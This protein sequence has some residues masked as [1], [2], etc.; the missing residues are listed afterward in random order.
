MKPRFTRQF[1]NRKTVIKM[2]IVEWGQ[3]VRPSVKDLISAVN[4]LESYTDIEHE[5][6]GTFL[7]RE[8]ANGLGG[9]SGIAEIS[10]VLGNTVVWNQAVNYAIN[11]NATKNGV[12]MQVF[13][14][15]QKVIISGEWEGPYTGDANYYGMVPD[16][17]SSYQLIA[18]HKYAVIT[19]FNLFSAYIYFQG[20]NFGVHQGS[21]IATASTTVTPVYATFRPNNASMSAQTVN[22]QG[23]FMMFDLTA[24]YGAGNEPQT[25]AEFEAQYGSDFKPY[26]TPT[27]L[28]SNIAGIEGAS[29]CEFP[30]QTLRSAG[31]AHDVMTKSK[32]ERNIGIITVDGDE[33]KMI[34]AQQQSN[35]K[36]LAYRNVSDRKNPVSGAN[37]NIVS[38]YTNWAT[39]LAICAENVGSILVGA[40]GNLCIGVG[41]QDDANAAKTAANAMLQSNPLILY[42]EL[43][44]PT[45]ETFAE[46]LDLTYRVESDGTEAWIVPEGTSPTSSA[47]TATISYKMQYEYELITE[48]SFDNFCTALGTALNLDIEKEW[49]DVTKEWEFTIASARSNLNAIDISEREEL[50]SIDDERDILESNILEPIEEVDENEQR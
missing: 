10:R 14:P 40:T 42:Y 1:K 44:T 39:N 13:A 2:S 50:Y 25:V 29:S 47:P 33:T 11:H 22:E 27:L 12:Q 48:K 3:A 15:D 38:N 7:E 28:S 6:T 8:T 46:P 35:G 17:F 23:Y 21:Y 36:W 26:S 31:M 5:V 45:T 49:N 30:A 41:E 9:L 43:A 19:T 4:E 16:S 24:M 32:I 34:S 37:V 18:G 20:G